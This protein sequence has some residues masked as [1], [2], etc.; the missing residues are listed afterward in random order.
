MSIGATTATTGRFTTVQS[1]VATGTAP[2]IVASTTAVT[3]LN[4]DLLDGFNSAQASTVSTVAVRD[5][6][7]DI[8]VRL[9]RSEFTNEATISGAMAF[10]VNN[11]TDNYI[12]FCSDTPAIRTFLNVPTRT[13]GD[14]TGTWAISI[15]G[16]ANTANSATSATT[17]TTATNAT[18]V[19]VTT[20]STASA[21]KVPFANT[22]VNT[23]GNYGLLQDSEA[24]FTYNPS[25]NTLVAGTFSGA[26]SGNATTATTLQTTRAI[27]GVNFNGSAAVTIPANVT[28]R[29]TN[30]SGHLIFIGTTATGNQSVYSNTNFR[31]NPSTNTLTVTNL[32]ATSITETSSIAYKENVSPIDSA[33]DKVL[34]L[35]GVTYDRKDGSR[36]NEAGLI[37][38][39]VA[40]VLPNIV[41]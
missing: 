14:A 37:A 31:I 33:L 15:T 18:N 28:D 36:K 17:A 19:A 38:E 41:S 25:T 4:A 3:N 21:F 12:R 32:S 23:T 27:N 6:S 22:T 7:G 8:V 1:T 24:T 40:K 26:L 5:A 29:T 11:S 35:M 16:N 30:E 2:F 39:D 13:G 20:S 9:V 10:R 34:Q